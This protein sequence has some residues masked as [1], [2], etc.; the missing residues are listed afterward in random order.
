M[1]AAFAAQV[2][3]FM[4]GALAIAYEAH[5]PGTVQAVPETFSCTV[6]Y[7]HDG[8]TFGCTDGKRIGVAGTDAR[9]LDGSCLPG[10]PC[11]G[12]LPEQATAALG[13]LIDGQTLSCEASGPPR[14][15]IAAFCRRSDGKDVSCAMLES[16]TVARWD[17]NWGAHR[18][19]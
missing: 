17:L 11:P 19:G 1:R 7:V 14:S 2:A 13:R 12:A 16:G 4:G 10:H 8:D 15:R 6:A 9:E 5:R 18:C 3:L